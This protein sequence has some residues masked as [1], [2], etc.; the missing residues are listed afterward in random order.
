L[1]LKKEY[2]SENF[3]VL[4]FESIRSLNLLTTLCIGFIGLMSEKDSE[5]VLM[6]VIADEASD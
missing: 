3:R 6:R 2:A 5:T 4:F 1:L